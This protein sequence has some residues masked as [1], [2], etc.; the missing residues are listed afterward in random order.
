[1]WSWQ[2]EKKFFFFFSF[3]HLGGMF[4]SWSSTSSTNVPY[5][6]AQ[7]SSIKVMPKG[8]PRQAMAKGRASIPAP[9]IEVKLCCLFLYSG[10]CF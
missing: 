10:F 9:T 5:E 1:M 8:Q 2:D 7:L 4:C 3:S 6:I